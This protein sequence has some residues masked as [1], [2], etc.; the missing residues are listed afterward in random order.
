MP[1]TGEIYSS[2]Y[3]AAVDGA[4][5][6]IEDLLDSRAQLRYETLRSDAQAEI[7][8]AR[9]Q[10]AEEE[11]TLA[12]AQEE[13]DAGWETYYGEE[14]DVQ[15]ALSSNQARLDGFRAQLDQGWGELNAAR[16]DPVGAIPEVADQVAAMEE[17]LAGLEAKRRSFRFGPGPPGPSW[18]L[19]TSRSWRWIWSKRPS[20][21]GRRSMRRIAAGRR[22]SWRPWEAA[23]DESDPEYE[24]KLAAYQAAV[25]EQNDRLSDLERGIKEDQADLDSRRAE[26]EARRLEL[27]GMLTTLEGQLALQQLQVDGYRKAMEDFL[28]DPAGG[29]AG[30]ESE[31]G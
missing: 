14:D 20:T 18:R 6:E 25:K 3:Q 1:S 24:Q 8:D 13:I 4:R 23:L 22:T 2:E 30:A 10:L 21:P 26:L 17:I 15:S 29:L 16:E 31:A 7:D 12:D 5:E 11:E 19:W 9:D 27:S 28:A